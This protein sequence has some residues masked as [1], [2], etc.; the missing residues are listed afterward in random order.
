MLL[1]VAKWVG[2]LALGMVVT[3]IA[4][5]VVAFVALMSLFIIY[6]GY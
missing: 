2:I 4:L 6:G 3:Y 5:H 1:K